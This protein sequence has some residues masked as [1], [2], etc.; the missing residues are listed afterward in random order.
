MKNILYKGN[1]IILTRHTPTNHS[2]DVI[3][4]E[5]SFSYSNTCSNEENSIDIAK[6]LIDRLIEFGCMSEVGVY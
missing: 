5:F 1:I 6:E 3:G 4:Y 2:L